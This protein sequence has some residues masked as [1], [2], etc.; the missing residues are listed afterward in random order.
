MKK[1]EFLAKNILQIIKILLLI[2]ILISPFINYKFLSVANI[3]TFKLIFIILI[4]VISFIDLQLAILMTLAF[5]ILVIN[6][7][8]PA[9]VKT[10]TTLPTNPVFSNN[11]TFENFSIGIPFEPV[12]ETISEFPDKCDGI[13]KFDDEDMNT[14][15]YN[16]Y[17]D[18]K[19]KPYENFIRQLSSPELIE[20]ASGFNVF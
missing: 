6:L 7:N 18:P 11:Q 19:I 4:A 3:F 14:N 2:Y 1:T 13:K 15:M 8:M 16:I 20:K 12:T 10:N 9:L 5:L 17:I